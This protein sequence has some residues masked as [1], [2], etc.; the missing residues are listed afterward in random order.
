MHLSHKTFCG[1]D[2]DYGE[3]LLRSFLTFVWGMREAVLT[4]PDEP[5]RLIQTAHAHKTEHFV[6]EFRLR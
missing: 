5:I 3:S 6:G 1:G 4:A 2:F